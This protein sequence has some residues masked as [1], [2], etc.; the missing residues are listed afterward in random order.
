MQFLPFARDKGSKTYGGR[1][2]GAN[3]LGPQEE[4]RGRNTR[5]IARQ[6]TAWR[7]WVGNSVGGG[8]AGREPAT[9]DFVVCF[10]LYINLMVCS[11]R[12]KRNTYVA[13]HV[14]CI[15]RFLLPPARPPPTRTE[16]SLRSLL[17]LERKTELRRW[18]NLHPAPPL[19]RPITVLCSETQTPS[20]GSQSRVRQ[21]LQPR[22]TRSCKAAR[23]RQHLTTFCLCLQEFERHRESN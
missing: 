7:R 14:H 22:T 16:R 9:T 12:F 5:Y 10:F 8:G 13:C 2:G 17:F 11:F 3:E 19:Q 23:G 6:H 21:F 18:D 4:K 1:G 20:S 15:K